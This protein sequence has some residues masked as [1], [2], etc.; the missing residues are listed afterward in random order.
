MSLWIAAEPLVLASKSAIRRQLLDAAG[1]PVEIRPA[2]IDERALEGAAGDVSAADVARLLATAKARDVA[3][4]LRG[5]IVLG[6]DQ[7]LGFG[8]RTFSKAGNRAAARAQLIK[9]RG[10]THALH[11]AITLVQGEMILFEHTSTA[12][13]TMRPFS[14]AFLDRYLDGIGPAALQ[15]VGSYQ[16]EAG[17][18]HLFEEIEGDHFTILGLPLLPLLDFLRQHGSLAA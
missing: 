13:L 14:D 3:A 7:T 16:L 10:Q 4:Q 15:S 17:G 5:R 18:I 2:E 11:S 6:A 1:I 12:R 9:L 8:G